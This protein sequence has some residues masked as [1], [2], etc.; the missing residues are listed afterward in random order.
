[1][2]KSSIASAQFDF[3]MDCQSQ[4]VCGKMSL[5]YSAQETTRSGASSRALWALLSLSELQNGQ[6]RVLPLDQSD[7]LPGGLSMPNISAYPNDAT[8]CSLSD[9]LETGPIPR[10]FYLSSRACAGILRRAER[11][12]KKLPTQ[13]EEALRAVASPRRWTNE[14]DE[15][16]K[17]ALPPSADLAPTL[18][19]N[20][21]HAGDCAP[22]TVTEQQEKDTLW[23]MSRMAVR[24]LTPTE[25]CRL[26]GFPDAYLDIAYRGK[27]AC[28]GPKYKALGNSFAVPVIHWLGK[29]LKAYGS[30]V[31]CA[32]G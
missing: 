32:N 30:S 10:R 23:N 13:L 12:G 31:E 25:C 17:P 15:A 9:V 29:R 4:P 19:S 8:V 5:E 2:S 26:Q 27:P 24:R 22:C 7:G 14:P 21:E 3:A 20:V 28:D 6:A 16:A 18:T 1:M 11:R